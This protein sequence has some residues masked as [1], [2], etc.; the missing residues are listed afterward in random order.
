MKRFQVMP[1]VD[2]SE[3]SETATEGVV[4]PLASEINERCIIFF[5]VTKEVGELINGLLE[6]EEDENQSHSHMLDVFK[7]MIESWVSSDRFLSGIFIDVVYDEKE[8]QEI[9]NVHIVLSST[10]DGFIEAIL[11]VNFVYAVILAILEDLDIMVSDNLFDKLLP[12]EIDDEVQQSTFDKNLSDNTKLYP[13]DKD[14]LDIA[15]KIMDGKI[16]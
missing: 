14:I 16:K 7:T 10:Q 12:K 2:Q 8:K 4:L 3:V 11:K 1:C 9:M 5:P 6:V 15:R 13:T